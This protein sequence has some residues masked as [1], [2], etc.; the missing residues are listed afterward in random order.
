MS[1]GTIG[2]TVGGTSSTIAGTFSLGARAFVQ[3]ITNAGF[4]LSSSTFSFNQGSGQT[5]N[6]STNDN[7]WPFSN[8]A[9]NISV[10]SG[11][12]AFNSGLVRNIRSTGT[13]TVASGATLNVTGATLNLVSDANGTA[14]INNSAG[15]INGNITVQRFIPEKLGRRWTFVSSPVSQQ[16]NNAWQQQIYITGSTSGTVCTV[17]GNGFDIA[18]APSPS[19]FT[20][21]ATPVNGTRWRSIL[22]TTSN[23][24]IG[25]GYRV[26]IR[27][28]RDNGGGCTNQLNS[29]TPA[30]P[31][32][33]TLSA[34]GAYVPSGTITIAGTTAHGGTEAYSLI[35]NP[36]PATMAFA[37]F[38]ASNS[39]AIT[40]QLWMFSSNNNVSNNY[41]SWN[42]GTFSGSWPSELQN[43]TE[44]L[45]PSGASFFVS[46]TQT[47]DQ[48][49][50]FGQSDKHTASVGGNTTFSRNSQSTATYSWDGLT[51]ITLQNSAGNYLD[52]AV[53]RFGTDADITNTSN[54][55]FDG[56][57]FNTGNSAFITT[58]KAGQNLTFNTRSLAFNN[59]TVQLNVFSNAAGNYKLLFSDMTS[60][61]AAGEVVLRDKF[62]NQ[63]QNVKITPDYSFAV[64]TDPASVGANRFDLV[65]RSA[66][67]LP[68]NF[69]LVKAQNVGANSVAVQWSVPAEVDI[70]E[71]IVERSANGT[72][73]TQRG[74]V[75]ASTNGTG[76]LQYSF[77]DAPRLEGTSFYRIK[78]IAKNGASKYSP[79][80]SVRSGKAVETL[81]V[82]PNPVATEATILLQ[83]FEGNTT[84]QIQNMSGIAVK[85]RVINATQANMVTISVADLPA[86]LYQVRAF[87]NGTVV[88][89][90]LIKQ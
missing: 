54:G 68:V 20:Y 81:Q 3:G 1:G 5:Y 2:L 28:T 8:V 14:Q 33:V 41:M 69:S 65:F 66:A 35:G 77:T 51:R 36:H 89:Q 58:V 17:D 43:V 9:P 27:G 71:Y 90:K 79:V 70:K 72:N 87:Q 48:N 57:S 29:G 85:Q 50:V 53:V 7:T 6:V 49:L 60:F 86:G 19:M 62:L 83:G 52:D 15:T 34:T 75:A 25:K 88:T 30:A 56:I 64:T 32:A 4:Y 21:E 47:A 39:S 11:T 44:P 46:T 12:V 23:L 84:L 10:A 45:I 37:N 63:N 40:N 76:T 78:V 24:S 55:K 26:N 73:F 18:N 61:T 16:I 82:L 31:N 22:N 59:D 38:R 42:A 74:T 13:L 67:T 80:V